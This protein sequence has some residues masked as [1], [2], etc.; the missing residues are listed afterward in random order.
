MSKEDEL[1]D[2]GRT[3]LRISAIGLGCWQFSRGQGLGG[4]YW[5]YVDQAEVNEIVRASLEGGVNWFDTAEAYG[6]GESERAL[7]RALT[8]LGRAPGQVVI[9]TKWRP[10]FR[11]ASSILKTIAVRRKNLDGFPI[12]L[13]Q[14]HNPYSFS[15]L[16]DEMAAMASL[17]LQGQV[18]NVGV[19]NFS[20][21]RMRRAEGALA[22]RGL[23][24]AS[25]QVR[26]SLLDRSIE[27]NGVL[28]L[29]GRL[30]VTIIAYSPL[31]QGILTGK[32]HDEP[33]LIRKRPGYRKY[34]SAFRARG[35]ARSRPV[36]E[37][38]RETAARHGATP[39]QVALSWV[40]RSRGP[41]V[42]A[43]PG[44]TTARQAAENAG[45]LRLE[46]TREEMDRL[47]EVSA[48]FRH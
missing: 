22:G 43:I 7:A 37:A 47:S 29:A 12:D 20:A 34:M 3:G 13:Y 42:V 28:D 26:Y 1:R 30:G 18:R 46:L 23:H 41:L 17:V 16:E 5:G 8:R 33:G 11:R 6:H 32:F 24:L 31:A 4:R 48:P 21:D 27:V 38:V 14:V 10:V 19:S 40:I 39:A 44:A 45:A 25:N 35:L 2:L 9:A 15:R 36:V